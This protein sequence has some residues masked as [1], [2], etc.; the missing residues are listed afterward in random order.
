MENVS[1]TLYIPL[2]G[3]A[4]VSRKGILLRDP[5]AEEIWEKEGFALKGKSASKWLA[6]NMG[7]RARIFDSWTEQQLS[8][9]PSAVVVHIGCGMDS[10]V[11]RVAHAGHLWY[12]IDFPDVIG[13]RQRHYPPMEGYTMIPS[14]ARDTGYLDSIPGEN[15]VVSMEGISMY[16]QREELVRLLADLHRHFARVALLMDCYTEFGAKASKFKNPV[17]EVGVTTLYG[18][19]DPKV[20]EQAGFAFLQEHS[21]TPEH[22]IREL[23]GFEQRFFRRMFAGSFAKKI[24]RL[25][26]YSAE[27]P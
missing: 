12:D 18:M 26:E 16:L 2:Y 17:N 7:M 15:A 19:D 9:D 21:L 24:Y 27:K 10:R 3:K 23:T 5:K 4:L 22:L 14:D 11:C 1:K 20:P 8:R 6:Y 13:Q 25:Y